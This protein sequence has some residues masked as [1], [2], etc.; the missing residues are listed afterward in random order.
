MKMT[1]PA[2]VCKSENAALFTILQNI[3]EAVSTAAQQG[4]AIHQRE[5]TV[6]HMVLQMGRAALALFLVQLGTGDQGERITL[7]EGSERQRLPGTHARRYVSIFGEFQLQRTV[8]G[9]T[10]KQKID[11]V[12]LDNRLQLPASVFSYV[13]QN[14]DQSLCVEEAFGQ[15]AGTVARMLGLQQAVDSL[16]RMN[17]Q[18][19]QSVEAFRAERMLPPASQEGE[20][21]VSS[22]DGKGVVMRRGED[23]Q[24]SPAHRSKGEKASRK[25]MAIVGAVY[26]VDRFVRTPEQVVAALF[27][28]DRHEPKRARP[29]PCHKQT[30]ASL[31]S[32]SAAGT[33]SGIEGTYLWL[34]EELWQ[35][36]H[37]FAKE[38]V[39]RCDGQEALW[40]ARQEFLPQR[41]T[42]NILDLLHVTPRLWQAAHVFHPEKSPQVEQFVRQRV[43]QVLEGKVEQ[44]IR[45]L[46][47]LGTKQKLR[48]NKKATLTK[49]C[50]YL[51]NNR[52]RMRYDEYL[53]KGYP[54]ASG[55][56]EGACRHLVKDRMERAGMHWT[57]RG[58]QAMLDVRSI[59]VNGDWDA[60][61]TFR[62]QRETKKLY[63][64]REL[65]EGENYRLAV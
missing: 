17:V 40:E 22:A 39:H 8:Y 38:M 34:M 15:A 10:E 24:A 30:M 13:L 62:I 52:E 41:N 14:W 3:Q 64:W 51:H 61:Q 45:G 60:Y 55:V 57:R 5:E 20:V 32:K 65:I 11:F 31:T 1:P 37:G 25:A 28:E 27:G 33:V 53:A 26:T 18:M 59:H 46:R 63:P 2:E 7:P 21:V 29:Q 44:V 23:D 16:E 19:A 6:W 50:Q 12:P 42:V 54:I 9:Q 35:R 49:L 58:A 36:N 56:I 43:Q 48:G 4:T 47:A